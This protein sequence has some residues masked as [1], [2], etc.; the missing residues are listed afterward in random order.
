MGQANAYRVWAVAACLGCEGYGSCSC[1]R[2]REPGEYHEVSMERHSLK[3][4][5]A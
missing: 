1:E 3:A 4:A 2:C 5:D